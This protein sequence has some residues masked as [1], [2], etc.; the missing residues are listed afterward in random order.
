MIIIKS[1]LRG[2]KHKSQGVGI[3]FSKNMSIHSY[4]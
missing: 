1:L 3:K 2:K 4:K